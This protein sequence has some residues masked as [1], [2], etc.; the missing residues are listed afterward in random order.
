MI[1]RDL[2]GP[3]FNEW[4]PRICRSNATSPAVRIRSPIDHTCWQPV[5]YPHV[6][7]CV[8]CGNPGPMRS[9]SR[10]TSRGSR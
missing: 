6:C 10:E 4:T 7:V 8:R 9:V 5:A 1:P 2:Y 3:C